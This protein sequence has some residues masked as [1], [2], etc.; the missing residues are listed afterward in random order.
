[1]LPDSNLV[2]DFRHAFLGLDLSARLIGEADFLADQRRLSAA[3][4]LL[5]VE[6]SP[7][8]RDAFRPLLMFER[9]ALLLVAEPK[10]VAHL[11]INPTLDYDFARLPLDV[12]ECRLRLAKLLWPARLELCAPLRSAGLE[13][14]QNNYQAS[15]A[16][17]DLGLTLLEWRL[18]RFLVAGAGR[19]YSREQ[20]LSQV[21]QLDYFG[22]LR[23]VDVH[24]RR[25]RQKL[26]KAAGHLKTVRGVGYLWQE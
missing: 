1:V 7:A 13:I 4:D 6:I 18:L 11:Q 12:A 26:G 19:A 23:T 5:V 24:V 9:P 10:L 20:L 8:N 21:W 17:K 2:E 14:D 25:L 15:L 22:D 16:G 3:V